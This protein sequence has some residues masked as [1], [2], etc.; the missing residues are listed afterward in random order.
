M[1]K[2]EL[3]ITGNSM[4]ARPSVSFYNK[5]FFFMFL[6]RALDTETN[7]IGCHALPESLVPLCLIYLE[8]NT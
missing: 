3:L 6:L 5:Y 4:T 8:A 7:N 1:I 2:T